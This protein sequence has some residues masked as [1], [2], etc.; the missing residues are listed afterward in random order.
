M[1]IVSNKLSVMFREFSGCKPYAARDLINGTQYRI[2]VGPDEE[3]ILLAATRHRID[4]PDLSLRDVREEV[5][6]AKKFLPDQAEQIGHRPDSLQLFY[7]GLP[8]HR[9]PQCEGISPLAK[10]GRAYGHTFP[11]WLHSAQVQEDY[12][13][14][15]LSI[16]KQYLADTGA[17]LSDRMPTGIPTVKTPDLFQDGI[18]LIGHRHHPKNLQLLGSTRGNDLSEVTGENIILGLSLFHEALDPSLAT[19]KKCALI[20]SAIRYLGGVVSLVK[21]PAKDKYYL[22]AEGSGPSD[23][24]LSPFGSAY[25]NAYFV[26]VPIIQAYS[27]QMYNS[28]IDSTGPHDPRVYYIEVAN[29]LLGA[30]Q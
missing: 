19:E 10:F 6:L 23:T 21:A 8:F 15:D 5:Q 16:I 13:S 27:G 3:T 12:V 22:N 7:A 20:E 2:V 25:N 9:T 26:P 17:I 24:G 29:R 4:N 11:R 28:A 18:I 30:L 14:P 1:T